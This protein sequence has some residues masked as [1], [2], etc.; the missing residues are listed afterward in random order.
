MR[1]CMLVALELASRSKVPGLALDVPKV[2]QAP[3]LHRYHVIL[4]VLQ[5]QVPAS[6]AKCGAGIGAGALAHPGLE[7]LQDVR[8]SLESQHALPRHV[9][10]LS[11]I[12]RQGR[13]S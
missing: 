10:Y 5:A 4:I 1:G 11:R 12:A 7:D 9:I 8:G 13:S 2:A 6:S 3:R